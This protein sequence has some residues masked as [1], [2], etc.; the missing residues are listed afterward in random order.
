[1]QGEMAGNN[2]VTFEADPDDGRMWAA[3]AIECDQMSKVSALKYLAGGVTERCHI[4]LS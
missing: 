1:M 4:P 3:V 2:F